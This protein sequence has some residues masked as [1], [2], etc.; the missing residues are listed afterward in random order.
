MSGTALQLGREIPLKLDRDLARK[1]KDPGFLVPTFTARPPTLEEHATYSDLVEM[2]LANRA[3]LGLVRAC[4]TGHS[5]FFTP[6]GVEVK[7]EKGQLVG[8]YLA[9]VLNL[10][11]KIDRIGD[12]PPDVFPPSVSPSSQG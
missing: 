5:D 4:I 3:A 6:D 8:F 10:A 12:P 1:E 11:A 7:F 2:N 9:D